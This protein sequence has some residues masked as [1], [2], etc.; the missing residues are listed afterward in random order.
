MSG[1]V[2]CSPASR[3]WLDSPEPKCS[4]FTPGFP[5]A[6]SSSLP[7]SRPPMA[8]TFGC[9]SPIKDAPAATWKTSSCSGPLENHRLPLHGM[10][11]R[12]WTVPANSP[13]PL[14]PETLLG[15]VCEMPP[16]LWP[17]PG[18]FLTLGEGG[19]CWDG[20]CGRAAG[21]RSHLWDCTQSSFM[22]RQ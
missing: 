4:L 8:W 2:L 13:Q 12:A 11:L 21:G 20:C 6:T 18:I 9:R 14:G 1:D 5:F 19:G 15:V 7:E 3:T 17:S 10:A 16:P 22:A